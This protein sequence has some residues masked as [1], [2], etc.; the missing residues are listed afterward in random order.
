MRWLRLLLFLAFCHNVFADQVVLKNGDK[1]S[2]KI[3]RAD[4]KNLVIATEFAGE[5]TVVWDAVTGIISDSPLYLTL[6]DGRTVSGLVTMANSRVEIRT[7]AG[8]PVVNDKAAVSVVRSEAEHQAYLRQLD[9]GWRDQWVGDANLGVALAKGNSDTFNAALGLAISRTTANDKTAIYAASL[10]ST[11]STSGDSRTTANAIRSGLR[12]D[13]NINRKWFGYGFTDFEHDELQELKLRWVLGGGLGYHLIRN[14][15]TQLDLL[16]GLAWNQEYFS[17]D[18]NDRSSAEAQVGQTLEHKLGSRS[19][20]KEQ[21]YFFPNLT[22]GGEYR[23]NFD[24]SLYMDI[25]RR[26]GWRLGLS[27]RYLSNPLPGL[28]KNDLIMTTG[29][30]VKIGGR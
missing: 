27:D 6:A 11:D 3:V 28:E 4:G 7:P 16:G 26:I 29:V 24:A 22:R 18:N 17:G 2:G 12:Y 5:V 19:R 14:E 9:P 1:L 30:S 10:Y 15:A 21:F 20:I 23:I 25:T 8:S 13:R